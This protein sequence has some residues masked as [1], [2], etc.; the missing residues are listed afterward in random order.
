MGLAFGWMM[1]RFGSLWVPIVCHA[2]WNGTYA[3]IVFF[4]QAGAV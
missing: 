4:G 2:A 3:L 1:Y